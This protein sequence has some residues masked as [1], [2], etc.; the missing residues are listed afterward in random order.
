[1]FIAYHSTN[2]PDL[3]V[4]PFLHV[5]T[6]AK[7]SMRGGKYLYRIEFADDRK[8]PRLRDN[9]SWHSKDLKRHA[10]KAGLI[11]YLNRHEGIPLEEFN[12]AQADKQKIDEMTDA[13]FVKVIP[14]AQDSWIIL[15]PDCVKRIKKIPG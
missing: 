4:K 5:G 14:S 13:R 9:G 3:K 11:I 1:M 8:I 6:Q 2:D 10:R 15:D 12:Q 7:A